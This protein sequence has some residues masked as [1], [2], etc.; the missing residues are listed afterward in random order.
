MENGKWK[1]D[2]IAVTVWIKEGI[3]WQDVNVD[4]VATR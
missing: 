3:K 4:V 2:L 1:I